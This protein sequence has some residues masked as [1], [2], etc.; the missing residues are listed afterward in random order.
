[1]KMYPATS[2]TEARAIENVLYFEH[3]IVAVVS[4]L[5]NHVSWSEDY[6]LTDDDWKKIDSIDGRTKANELLLEKAKIESEIMN[7]LDF[8]DNISDLKKDLCAIDAEL[9]PYV[10]RLNIQDLVRVAE[11]FAADVSDMRNGSNPFKEQKPER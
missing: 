7:R 8:G 10:K 3:D 11:G 1:M 5:N 2:L 6:E 4:T 9:E